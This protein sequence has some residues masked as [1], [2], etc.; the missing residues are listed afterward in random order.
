[1][2]LGKEPFRLSVIDAWMLTDNRPETT[3]DG[4]HWVAEFRT[5][6]LNQRPRIGEAEGSISDQVST[7]I[8]PPF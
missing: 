8:Q 6:L 3:G 4:F 7:D 5:D 1:M 2:H